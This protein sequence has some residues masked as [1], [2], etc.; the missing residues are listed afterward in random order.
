M[1]REEVICWDGLLQSVTCTCT[2]NVISLVR[3]KCAIGAYQSFEPNQHVLGGIFISHVSGW[4]NIESV[5]CFCPSV[6]QHSQSQT[7]WR[8]T[9]WR[10]IHVMSVWQKRLWHIRGRC[11]NAW[12]FSFQK[13]FCPKTYILVHF[14]CGQSIIIV[15]IKCWRT[16]ISVHL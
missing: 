10:Q 9:S 14:F 15:R 8:M 16:I 4:G 13:Y 5:P 2:C 1:A 7:V 3:G 6:S 11:V 12:A